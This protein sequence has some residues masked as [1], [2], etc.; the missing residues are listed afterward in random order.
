[1]KLLLFFL[2]VIVAVP[3]VAQV[4]FISESF[5]PPEDE[6]A[7]LHIIS[8]KVFENPSELSTV[9]DGTLISDV[10]F[11]RYARRK[12]SAPATAT[13][14][15]E[16]VTATDSRAAYSLLTL[17]R[18][19]PIQNGPP[20][21]AFSLDPQGI[22]FAQNKEWIRIRAQGIP[23]ELIRKIAISVGN[24]IGQRKDRSPSLLSHFPKSGYDASSLRYF[25]GLKSYEDYAGKRIPNFIKL[26]V[27]MEVAQARYSIEKYSGTLFLLNFPTPQIAEAYFDEL[28]LPASRK[29]T[30]RSLYARRSGPLIGFLEGD[31]DAQSA[32]TILSSIKFSYAVRWVYE[33]GNQSKILWGI[34]V[35]ILGTVVNS[36]LFVILLCGIS[37]LIGAMIA[38]LS[39]SRRSR[40]S[41]NIPTSQQSSEI[42]RLRLE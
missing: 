39:F 17:L 32:D 8:D 23:D 34:P 18:S 33:K 25:P 2:I 11:T 29:T 38:V 26:D 30:P 14:T 5:F 7:D 24:R 16:A 13:I 31:F 4:E 37:I 9:E 41:Q 10:G 15:V 42:T 21:D 6:F 3:A 27:D 36:V 40:A 1:M 22:I 12:Y 35:R 28:V 19:A 20:G